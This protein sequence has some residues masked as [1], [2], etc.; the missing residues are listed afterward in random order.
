MEAPFLIFLIYAVVCG[1][2]SM[3]V[4][5]K[6]GHSEGAWF[7]AGLLCGLLGLIA[8]AGLPV[9]VVR[10]SEG[11]MKKCPDCAEAIRLEAWV[12]KHCG[13]RSSEMEFHQSILDHPHATRS[14]ERTSFKE[15]CAGSHPNTRGPMAMDLIRSLS[16]GLYNDGE[17]E[18]LTD[19]LAVLQRDRVDAA[20]I[21]M[22]NHAK[23]LGAVPLSES[24]IGAVGKMA[25]P[26]TLPALLDL[27]G[28]EALLEPVL[29][30]LKPLASLAR[31]ELERLA[32]AGNRKEKKLYA[33]ALASLGGRV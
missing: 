9:Q 25:L 14:A 1:F 4:A 18:L 23:K 24:L 26:A 3:T 19:C 7:L 20:A 21:A 32:A 5:G 8:A 6:K 13:R 31:P 10:K 28:S 12:C 30:A 29:S 33:Q 15:L 27:L 17:K 22:L 11:P 16:A 2:L